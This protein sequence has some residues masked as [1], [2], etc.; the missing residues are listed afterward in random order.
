MSDVL[1]EELAAIRRVREERYEQLMRELEERRLRSNP[2]SASDRE[3]SGEV[4][5]RDRPE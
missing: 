3:R 4:E 2:P 5:Q 1:T